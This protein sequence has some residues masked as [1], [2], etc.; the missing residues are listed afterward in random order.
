MEY[1]TCA[2]AHEL[3]GITAR[4]IQQMCKDGNIQG[5][6]KKGRSWIIPRHTIC[7]SIGKNTPII[8]D[9]TK[10]KALPIGVADFK[11]SNH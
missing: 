3:W 5:A 10:K 11:K 7:P 8:T 2:E 1:M 9:T 6:I 4:R